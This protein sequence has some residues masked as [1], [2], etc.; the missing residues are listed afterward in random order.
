MI[1]RDFATIDQD[2]NVNGQVEYFIGEDG[3]E[4]FEINL[5]HQGLLTLKKKLDYES[6]K[7]HFVNIIARVSLTF[8]FFFFNFSNL[9]FC[10]SLNFFEFSFIGSRSESGEPIFRFG[11][12][13]SQRH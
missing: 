1:F 11:H 3:G 10:S 13:N 12:I 6:Q 7:T 8:K 9:Q 4:F 2:S 5:P